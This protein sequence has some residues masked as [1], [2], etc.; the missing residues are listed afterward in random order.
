MAGLHLTLTRTALGHALAAVSENPVLA[1]VNGI[2]LQ[3]TIT[4]AWIIGGGL[5]ALAGVAYGLTQQLSPVM[6]RDLVLAL[7]A[8]AIL[9]GLGHVPG[10]VLGGFVVGLASSLSLLVL[11]AGY[12]PAIPFLVILAVLLLRPQGLFGAAR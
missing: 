9:G 7:F 12:K 10:A 1:Q 11:P 3:R 2:D 5:A 8:A 4:V 6:G